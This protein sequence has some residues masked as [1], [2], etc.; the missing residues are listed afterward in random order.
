VQFRRNRLTAAE[1]AQHYGLILNRPVEAA[2]ARPLVPQAIDIATRHGVPIYDALFVAL[3]AD[4]GLPG[5]TADE[6][7]YRAVHADH[8]QIQL[9]R[10]WQPPP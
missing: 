3:T 8:P 2:A 10:L 7:L 5:V 1:V 6:S 4:R 9:L